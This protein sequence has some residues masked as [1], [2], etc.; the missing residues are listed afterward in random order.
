MTDFLSAY[1]KLAVKRY[2]DE[3]CM[4]ITDSYTAPTR[5]ED[6]D[7][8]LTEAAMQVDDQKLEKLFQMESYVEHHRSE[9]EDTRA[10]MMIAR[11]RMRCFLAGAAL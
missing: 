11:D 9:L 5:I 6:I 8:K 2:I 1:W 4:T 7:S 10:K 3:V